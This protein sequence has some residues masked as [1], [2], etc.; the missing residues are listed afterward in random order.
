[1]LNVIVVL[2]ICGN[3]LTY[4]LIYLHVKIYRYICAI[5]VVFDFMTFA[6]YRLVVCN[7]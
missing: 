7:G 1:M 3:G 2:I 4:I 6:N 5:I